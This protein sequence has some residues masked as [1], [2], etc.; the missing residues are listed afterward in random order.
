MTMEGDGNTYRPH[1][2]FGGGDG[3]QGDL[4]HIKA[5]GEVIDLHSKESGYKFEAGDSVHIETASG[6]GYGDPHERPVEDVF[7]DYQD[8]LITAEIAREGYGVV[9]TDG[10]VDTEA[11]A[12]RRK[13]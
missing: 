6:G 4:K 3:T 5:D 13:D 12:Q 2:L 11:T 7:N 10:E 1:G 8:G 9:I